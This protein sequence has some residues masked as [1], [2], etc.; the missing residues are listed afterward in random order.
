MKTTAQPAATAKGNN[1]DAE[2]R[3]AGQASHAA[4]VRKLV[5]H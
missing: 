1:S 2:V 5:Q 3:A 4:F